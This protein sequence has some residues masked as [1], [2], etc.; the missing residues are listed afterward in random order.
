MYKFIKYEI[1]YWLSTPMLW[2]F[3]IINAL[4]I[5]GAVSSDNITIGGGT[6]S[7]HKN[8]PS[9][10]QNYY[11]VMSL[12]CLLMTTAFMN[13]TAN[14]DFQYGMY[15]FIFSSPIKKRDYYFGKFIGAT[16]VSIIPLL[17]VSLGALL[18]PIMPWAQPERYG[19]VIWSGHLMGLLTF[20]IPN[21]IISGVLLYALAIIFRNNIVSFV[22]AM[23]MLMLYAVSSGFL[24]DIEKEWL[25]NI[26]DPFGFRPMSLIGK[27][28][29]VDEKNLHPIYLTGG[30]LLN[31]LIWIGFSLTML[32]LLYFRFSFNTKKEKVKKTTESKEQHIV[33][34]QI[35]LGIKTISTY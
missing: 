9:V 16:I 17:G 1:K 6:G 24:Q 13:A 33:C 32:V 35:C 7:V 20:G 3:L 14:R 5:M 12:I 30:L 8:A 4:L 29:T 21:T 15:Q 2:I 19:E 25:V 18:G 23:L 27:Y 11:G 34:F 28:M 22:G 10:I 26:I 31:R